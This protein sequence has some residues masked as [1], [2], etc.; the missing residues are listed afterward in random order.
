M[1]T[2]SKA[3]RVDALRQM[4]EECEGF[5]KIEE[6]KNHKNEE[7]CKK[8]AELIEKFA[9]HLQIIYKHRAKVYRFDKDTKKWK[10]RGVGDIEILHNT[11]RMTYRI[12]LRRD[13]PH[14]IACNHY[15]TIDQ[16][17]EP[18]QGSETALTWV[19]MDFSDDRRGE[20]EIIA[21]RFKLPET[22]EE[23][24]KAFETAQD[25]M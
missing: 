16:Q 21:V 7:V 25:W 19:A 2:A 1:T 6:L 9:N 23:F 12:L 14:K 17:L 18:I 4:I 24:K 22:K 3:G 5:D 20:L 13:Q 8:A 15:I 10:E 11:K